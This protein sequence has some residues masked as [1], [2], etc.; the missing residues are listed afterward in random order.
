MNWIGERLKAKGERQK[1]GVRIRHLG[2]VM[3]AKLKMIND[4]MINVKIPATR[5]VA[6]GQSAVFYR[7][8]EVLGGG[9]ISCG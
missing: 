1:V 8:E 2:E 4:Q 7:G 9:V 3:P 5:G 6:P